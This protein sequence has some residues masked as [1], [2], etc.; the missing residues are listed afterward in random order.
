MRKLLLAM[1]LFLLAATVPVSAM[2]E[3]GIRIGFSLPPP[4]TFVA[5][6]EVIA[7]PDTDDVYVAPDVDVDL[8]FWGGWWWRL[9]EGRWYRSH[10]YDRG[11]GYYRHIP[12]F[13]YH[14]DPGWRGYYRDHDWRGHRWDYERI[15]DRRLRDN[16]HSWR[17]NGYWQRQRSWGIQGYRPPSPRGREP[18]G[19]GRGL[20]PNEPTSNIGG[21]EPGGPG[22]NIDRGPRHNEPTSNIG[23]GREPGGPGANMDRGPRPAGPGVGSRPGQPSSNIDSR[24]RNQGGRPGQE[25]SEG[26]NAEHGR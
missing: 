9:W 4:V 3:V 13:Y 17:N 20:R 24:P 6:P 10:Y 25:R 16:W 15:P 26:G 12:R 11:W 5:P 18:G 2:A 14:V 19:P 7:L 1:V 22:S 8:F 21:R 23:R